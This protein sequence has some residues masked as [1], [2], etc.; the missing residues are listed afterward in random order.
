MSGGIDDNTPHVP[1][2][3]PKHQQVGSPRHNVPSSQ[4]PAPQPTSQKISSN[5]QEGTNA[6]SRQQKAPATDVAGPAAAPVVKLSGDT[7]PFSQSTPTTTKSVSELHQKEQTMPKMIIEP[8][9]VSGVTK[10]TKPSYKKGITEPIVTT[11]TKDEKRDSQRSKYYEVSLYFK[12]I[13]GK[14]SDYC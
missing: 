6:M 3:S 11:T 8:E 14:H 1:Y 4:Q 5:Q 9:H 2:P 7:K 10:E 12:T 13:K